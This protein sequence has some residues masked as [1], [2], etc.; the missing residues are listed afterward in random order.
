MSDQKT[1]YE[2]SPAT[3][4]WTARLF[5][6][7]R[8]VLAVNFKLHHREA[9]GGRGEQAEEADRVEAAACQVEQT[10]TFL[11]LQLISIGESFTYI[12]AV[13]ASGA[14]ATGNVD[15]EEHDA[16]GQNDVTSQAFTMTGSEGWKVL[17]VVHTITDADSDRLLVS[18][19][20]G[21]NVT[22]SLDAAMLIDG[23]RQFY[24]FAA[25]QTEPQRPQE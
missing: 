6:L 22:L 1:E 25:E 7:L 5:T 12:I 4:V 16:G 10:V 2:L 23:N 17:T 15:I 8:K 20:L 19:G 11:D 18:V 9:P 14:V 13:R 3:Y 24:W 21:D